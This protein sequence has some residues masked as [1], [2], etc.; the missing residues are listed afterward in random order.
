MIKG[1]VDTEGSKALAADL[2]FLT[3]LSHGLYGGYRKARV[4]D[5]LGEQG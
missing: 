4:L 5:G 2:L 3:L 1:L